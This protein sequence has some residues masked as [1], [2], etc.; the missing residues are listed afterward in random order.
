MARIGVRYRREVWLFR[1]QPPA[2]QAL[3]LAAACVLVAG[4][5]TVIVQGGSSNQHNA[6]ATGLTAGGPGSLGGAVAGTGSSSSGPTGPGGGAAG[7]T[8]TGSAA[9]SNANGT[10]TG[11]DSTSGR[12]GG[13]GH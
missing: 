3:S 2:V 7:A 13:G 5:L 9:G 8:G 4:I 1:H 10:G 12:S 6:S 11:S